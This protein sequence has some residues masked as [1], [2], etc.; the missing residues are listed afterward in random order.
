MHQKYKYTAGPS[1]SQQ[2]LSIVLGII[3]LTP[4]TLGLLLVLILLPFVTATGGR[5]I[6]V[7]TSFIIMATFGIISSWRLAIFQNREHLS[8][9][10]KG[11][12]VGIIL[13]VAS[14]IMAYIKMGTP[15]PTSSNAIQIFVYGGGPAI[16]SLT[17]L[18]VMA[19]R[20]FK[21][22]KEKKYCEQGKT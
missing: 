8:T 19:R 21:N 10:S 15:L 7:S 17:M 4:S 9:L 1:E 5:G 6:D 3:F 2:A 12:I 14:F 16:Y 18:A 13:G 22:K 20:D 11:V